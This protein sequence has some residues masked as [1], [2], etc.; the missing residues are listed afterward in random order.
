MTRLS[1]RDTT[2]GFEAL[3][4]VEA[5]AALEA[6]CAATV[7]EHGALVWT[8]AGFRRLFETHDPMPIGALVAGYFIEPTFAALTCAAAEGQGYRG[9]MTIG[10]PDGHARSLRAHAWREGTQVQ[11]LA[12]FDIA[13]LERINETAFGLQRESAIAHVSLLQSSQRLQRLHNGLVEKHSALV[14]SD[15]RH[16]LLFEEMQ[17]GCSINEI[18]TDADG[19]VVDFRVLEANAAYERHVGVKPE[20]VIGRTIRE[21]FPDAD[22]RQIARM[23]S[24]VETGEPQSWEYFSP[25]INRHLRVRAFRGLPRQFVVMYEDI[26]ERMA[27]VAA[28]AAARAAADAANAAKT[29]FLRNMSHEIRTPLNGIL[30]F[31]QLLQEEVL[32]PEVAESVEAIATSGTVLGQLIDDLLDMA[33]I[34][35]DRV[36]IERSAFNLRA[37]ISDAARII[38]PR[39]EDKMLS[40]KLTVA[41]EVP[42]ELIGDGHRITQIVLNLVGNAVK[43]TERGGVTVS[44]NVHERDG[45]TIMIEILVADTGI[46]MS[47]SAMLEVFEPFTQAE[48]SITRRFGG[49]G[50]GL[51]IC[52]QLTNLMGGSVTADSVEGVGSTFRVLL[53]LEMSEADVTSIDAAQR[54]S[55]T[56][57]WSGAPLT[58]LLVEDHRINQALGRAL[59]QK[60]GHTVKIAADGAEALQRLLEDAFDL[61]L[62]DIQM[63]VM[64]G[65]AALKVLRAREAVTGAHTRV[66]ALTAFAMQDDAE[67]FL[68][69]GFDGYVSKPLH[70]KFFALPPPPPPTPPADPRGG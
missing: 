64:D 16:R 19:Q 31:T 33:K 39:A 57:H 65:Q 48:H 44:V 6:V 21:V 1:A 40:L 17:E 5:L 54:V 2:E 28:L 68:A 70:V 56:L 18:I 32:S 63:P 37:C 45:S 55:Q 35:A 9:L 14:A 38:R 41:S 58:V 34:E 50:L 23:A 11:L 24:V 69:A 29:V 53:P 13:E 26:T 36:D 12:E 49:T 51:T 60:L 66:I 10:H 8:N 52:R 25:T 62:M 22:V 43:F 42:A 4:A 7:D 67:R 30:G 46:G 15:A 27:E 47:A 20:R 59:L 61:V 3:E